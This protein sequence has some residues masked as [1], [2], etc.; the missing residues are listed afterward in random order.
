[1]SLRASV[2]NLP[3]LPRGFNAKDSPHDLYHEDLSKALKL[4]ASEYTNAI[5]TITTSS[6]T[7]DDIQS[8]KH[9]ISTSMTIATGYTRIFGRK[10]TFTGSAKLTLAGTAMLVGVG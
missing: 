5:N 2:Q 7:L 10:I 9:S 1:M 3:Q 4:W 6:S 8:G